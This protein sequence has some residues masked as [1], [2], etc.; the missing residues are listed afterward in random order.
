MFNS[1]AIIE[2]LLNLNLPIFLKNEPESFISNHVM[3]ALH[4]V[5]GLLVFSVSYPQISNAHS[6]TQNS[7]KTFDFNTYF[8]PMTRFEFITFK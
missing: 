1:F 8:K 7:K 5:F 3:W 6:P 4:Q 2:R